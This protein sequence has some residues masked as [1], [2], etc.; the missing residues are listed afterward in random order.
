MK[1]ILITHA[2][3]DGTGCAIVFKKKY[4]DIEIEFRNHD[5]IDKRAKELLNEQDNYEKIYFADIT[6]TGIDIAE[7]VKDNNKFVL[8]DH[9]TSQTYLQ[10][11]RTFNEKYCATYLSAVYLYGNIENNYDLEKQLLLVKKRFHQFC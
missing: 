6:P 11:R 2:D 4:P 10:G 7:K 1:R 3:L 5:T 9:H 8:I